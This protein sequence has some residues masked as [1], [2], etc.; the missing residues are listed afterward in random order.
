MLNDKEKELANLA[1]II[2]GGLK[3]LEPKATS[4]Y[5]NDTPNEYAQRKVNSAVVYAEML[6]SSIKDL[7]L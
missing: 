5:G 6:I 4:L 7:K 1:A 3:D 2:L